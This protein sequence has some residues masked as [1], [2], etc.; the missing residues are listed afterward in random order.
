MPRKRLRLVP[1]SLASRPDAVNRVKTEVARD[2]L[3]S[4]REEFRLNRFSEC[5]ELCERITNDFP[6]AA[7]IREATSLADMIKSDPDRLKAV[8]D[9]QQERT[10][11]LYLA[12]AETWTKKGQTKEAKACLDKVISLCPGTSYAASAQTRL[13]NLPGGNQAVQTGFQKK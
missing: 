2:I 1:A 11:S 5:L 7:E 4:A 8:V 3:A 10:A 6:H 12:L 9:R 13:A